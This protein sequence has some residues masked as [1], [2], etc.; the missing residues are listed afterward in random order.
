MEVVISTAFSLVFSQ[1]YRVTRLGVPPR[2]LQNWN[3]P[4]RGP[5]NLD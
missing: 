2:Q 3:S 1:L 5:V 4:R